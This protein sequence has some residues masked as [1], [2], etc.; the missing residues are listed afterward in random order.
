[1]NGFDPARI[2][3]LEAGSGLLIGS[4]ALDGRPHGARAWSAELLGGARIRVGVAADDPVTVPSIDGRLV[5]VT[6]ADVRTVESV[7]V[8]GHAVAKGAPN[9]HDRALLAAQSEAFLRSIEE[10]DGDP[11]EYLRRLIPNRFEMI[12]VTIT[13]IYDQTPGPSAGAPLDGVVGAHP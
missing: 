11:I 6:A 13:E 9:E 8:K 5:A 3:M 1:M 2:A 10:T 7:Q 4:V 12:E